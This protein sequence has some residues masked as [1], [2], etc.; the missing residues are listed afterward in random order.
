MSGSYVA[1]LNIIIQSKGNNWMV[2][3]ACEGLHL[4]KKSVS[5][6]KKESN[7]AVFLQTAK[8]SYRNFKLLWFYFTQPFFSSV[9]L[10]LLIAVMGWMSI[11]AYVLTY[12]NFDGILFT[13]KNP[14][15][16]PVKRR[17]VYA[18]IWG[19]LLLGVPNGH[20]IVAKLFSIEPMVFFGK[21]SFSA[22]L[23]HMA[24]IK[25]VSQYQGITAETRRLEQTLL[26]CIGTFIVS[27]LRLLSLVSIIIWLYLQ[28][29]ANN[30]SI[31]KAGPISS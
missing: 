16:F 5:K 31:I 20:G 8:I 17:E 27:W 7:L 21:I 3:T 28:V 25:F 14:L 13:N 23:W 1:L 15:W 24:V 2:R 22:Y 6:T 12:G 10:H 30:Q 18:W 4:A 9:E 26:T 19:A 11:V 29:F